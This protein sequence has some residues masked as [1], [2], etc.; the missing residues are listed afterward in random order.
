[1]MIPFLQLV[2]NDLRAKYGNNLSQLTL[3][4]PNK[5]AS[6]FFNDY[7]VNDDTP[8]WA[9][10]YTTISDLFRSLSP[11]KSIDPIEA[12]CRIYNLYL[13]LT[14]EKDVSLD[15][16]YGWGE[17]ILSDFEDIDKKMVAAQHVL[18]NVKDFQNIDFGNIV[19]EEQAA[20]LRRFFA[21][22]SEENASVVKE[23][24]RRLWNQLLP[25]YNR[26]NADLEKEG[27][28]YEG[29]LY[30]KVVE[31]LRREEICLPEST[32]R[33]VFVGF[34]LLDQVE[35]KFF[36][37]LKKQGKALFYWDYDT[38]YTE[39]NPEIEAGA[40]IK[41]NVAFYGNE[42][43]REHFS[44]FATPKEIEFVAAASNSVQAAAVAPWLEKHATTDLKRTAIVLCDEQLL[45][46]VL[47][48]LPPNIQTLNITKGFPLLQTPAYTLIDCF[49]KEE[50]R[51]S[52][53]LAESE[54]LLLALAEALKTEGIAERNL[55][56]ADQA[57]AVTDV[58]H[59]LYN[60]AY[61][62]AYLMVNHLLDLVRRKILQANSIHLLRRLLRQL[63]RQKS[64]PFHGEPA[65]GVQ[66]MGM[67][68]TRNLDFENILLLSVN[69]GTVPKK[70]SNTSFIPYT[71]RKEFGLTT[72]ENRTAVFAYHFYHLLQRCQ[73]ARL[74]YNNASTGLQKGERSRFMSQLL[75]ECNHTIEH[76]V[77]DSVQEIDREIPQAI[78]K[79]IDLK[80]KIQRL[81]PSALNAY[82]ECPLRFYYS[83]VLRLETPPPAPEAFQANQIGS[84]FHKVA[85]LLYAEQAEKGLPVT[86][87]FLSPFLSKGGEALFNP[88]IQRA[89]EEVEIMPNALIESLVRTFLKNLVRYDL[90]QTPFMVTGLEKAH[91]VEI[92]VPLAEGE[93][94]VQIG[95]II[96]RQDIVKHPTEVVDVHRV[97]DYKTGGNPDKQEVK[98]LSQLFERKH[99]RPYYTFQTLIYCLALLKENPNR[100]IAPALF[101]TARAYKEEYSPY[102]T[103]E[104]STCYDIHELAESF[105]KE[106]QTLL[107]EIFDLEVEFYPT[108]EYTTC[109][110][111][112]FR[113]LC[114]K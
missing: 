14:E 33:Y 77:L 51:K 5:R 60:E 107:A 109:Q 61:Y 114:H 17:I 56:Q 3:V 54:D 49:F 38:Y 41:E 91:Y 75:V 22:F 96:D 71:I 65:M 106:L 30:R 34:N 24:F 101:Y 67:L 27:L 26:L 43:S 68:E 112:D 52:A 64:V 45:L 82:I 70:S 19:S 2:A 69:E 21:S 83:R 99:D 108:T 16:F 28:A 18:G 87:A 88:Y 50:E 44:N 11:L 94:S 73:H 4:F 31:G 98:S 97:F 10:T 90:K 92:N 89:Y 76:F 100:Y 37:Y 46:P 8:V 32:S 47:H 9:P 78:S 55:T 42:L 23:R 95:G 36:S 57:Q 103:I 6:L 59:A 15:F 63:V 84:L 80:E 102:L 35:R 48:N 93:H 79:P 66:I 29:A 72:Y 104:G 39:E 111:C 81:S 58:W 25:L 12:V 74:I 86:E 1:M 40:F 7:L 20:V 13:A 113:S 105:E 53:P 85:E 62:Q 110:L